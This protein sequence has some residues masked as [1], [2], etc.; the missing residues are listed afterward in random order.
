VAAWRNPPRKE[1]RGT[2]GKDIEGTIRNRAGRLR[3]YLPCDGCGGPAAPR[4]ADGASWPDVVLVVA[5]AFLLFFRAV[6]LVLLE[7]VRLGHAGRGS[8][9]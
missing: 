2:D 8:R 9:S 5:G 4:P 6:P 7:Q 1:F 3:G